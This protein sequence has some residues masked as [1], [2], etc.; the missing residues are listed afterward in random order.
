MPHIFVDADSCPVK[1]EIIKVAHRYELH[2]TFVTNS[3]MRMPTH[4]NLK[5]VLVDGTLDAADDWIVEHATLDDIVV[6]ADIPLAAR[7]VKNGTRVL[8]PH[9]RVYSETNIGDVL[10]T[11]D[12]LTDLR[13]VGALTTGPPPFQKKDRSQFL[14]AFDQLS[15]TASRTK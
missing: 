5:Q 1:Q 14:H 13:S 9:G 4:P 15:R 2:V 12:L 11:R 8:T 6:T 3:W 7:C 10:A